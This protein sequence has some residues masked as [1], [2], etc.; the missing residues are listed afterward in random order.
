[1][2]LEKVVFYDFHSSGTFKKVDQVNSANSAFI[3][4]TNLVCKLLLR[5]ILFAN[6]TNCCSGQLCG[7]LLFWIFFLCKILQ[8]VL[9]GNFL[10]ISLWI[11]CIC[12]FCILLFQFVQNLQ[13]GRPGGSSGLGD[14]GGQGGPGGLRDSGG[15]G[16][17]GGQA[18]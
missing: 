9:L 4:L 7:Q 6:S 13:N 11:I 15:P 3:S 18:G 8:I 2:Q 14:Q 16:D 12:E 1:M 5:I 10:E 17:Q